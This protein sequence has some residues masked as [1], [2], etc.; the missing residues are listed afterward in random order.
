MRPSSR[1]QATKN[2]EG[3]RDPEMHQ[4]KKG[5]QWHFGMKAHIAVD[6][7]SG[8][9]TRSPPRRPTRRTSSRSPICCMARNK[10]CGPTRA[11]GVP[12]VAW[13][14][15]VCSGT[16]QQGPVTLPS[17]RKAG[18]SNGSRSRSTARPACARRSSTRS[19]S[20]S[21]SSDWRRSDSGAGEEHRARGHAVRV[22]EPVDGAKEVDGD[23]R[24]SP[25]K[26]IMRREERGAMR[27]TH[28]KRRMLWRLDAA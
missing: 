11:T 2:A 9:G 7:D 28:T 17:C 6:A 24:S 27:L 5:N 18:P 16:S 14:E 4:T 26:S 1:R 25:S 15:R 10:T 22:V 19:G 23:G 21:A 13:P 12:K 20:S 3:E 8:L